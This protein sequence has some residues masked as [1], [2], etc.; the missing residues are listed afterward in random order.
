MA[1]GFMSPV[2][3]LARALRRLLPRPDPDAFLARST[4]IIHIGANIGQEA[5]DYAQRNLPVLWVE[6]IPHIY[7]ELLR[8][9]AAYPRQQAVQ[10]LLLSAARSGVTL[11]ISSN[12]GASS[13]VL[14]LAEHKKIWPE[15]HF[16]DQLVLDATTLDDLRAAHPETAGYNTLILDTQGTELDI[17]R[18]GKA[19]LPQIQFIK[20]EVADFESYAGGCQLKEM[21]EFLR[22][23]GFRR[24]AAVPF[25]SATRVGT[26]YDVLYSRS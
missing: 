2:R 5:P 15:V 17:I 11:N 1:L 9:I 22:A 3:R 12:H 24:R 6:P 25:A 4:G 7:Q 16:V 20:T 19:L 18:G 21:D 13:S 14:D 23:A 10:A 26:Y 8:N